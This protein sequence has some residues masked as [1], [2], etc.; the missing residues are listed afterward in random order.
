MRWLLAVLVVAPVMSIA[1]CSAEGNRSGV[2]VSPDM[3]YTLPYDPYDRNAATGTGMTL[4]APPEGS[5]PTDHVAFPYG[6][7]RDEADRAGRELGNPTPAD[8]ASVQRG[9]RVYDVY[10]AVCHGAEG[11]GDGP[12][13]GRFPNPPSLLADRARGLPDGALYHV[14]TTGQGIMASYAVQVRPAD[15]WHVINYIRTL[16]GG[17]P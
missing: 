16:Q 8:R 14:I 12:I 4:L 2:V 11:R 17:Q 3:A 13:I 6:P 9:K 15:R 7:G 10:C 5:I 1:A